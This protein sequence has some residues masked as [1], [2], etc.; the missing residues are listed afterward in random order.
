MADRYKGLKEPDGFRAEHTAH[1][2]EVPV[3]GNTQQVDL[4]LPH[5]TGRTG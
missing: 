1:A 4:Q 3:R 5:Q 2:I